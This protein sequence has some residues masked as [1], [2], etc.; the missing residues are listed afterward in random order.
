VA[1]VAA[2]FLSGSGR[3][4]TR[5]GIGVVKG[6]RTTLRHADVESAMLDQ[7]YVAEP[8]VV[9]GN[10]LLAFLVPGRT[11]ESG[12]LRLGARGRLLPFDGVANE[13]WA[14][15][16]GG[17]NVVTGERTKMGTGSL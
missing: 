1:E 13:N 15:G 17:I 10:I 8:E 2:L 16:N 4:G 9:S 7:V 12:S 14:G 3:A 6:G 5:Q 11:V